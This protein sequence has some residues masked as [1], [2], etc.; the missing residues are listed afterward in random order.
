MSKNDY[1]SSLVNDFLNTLLKEP[2]SRSTTRTE[3][4]S[5]QTP[6]TRLEKKALKDLTP[7]EYDEWRYSNC[8][9]IECSSCPFYNVSCDVSSS[10]SWVHHKDLYSDKF[11]NQTVSISVDIPEPPKFTKEEAIWLSSAVPLLCETSIISSNEL[12]AYFVLNS[13]RALV[14]Y[15]KLK[16][17]IG[18]FNLPPRFKFECLKAKEVYSLQD[19]KD[20]GFDAS[21]LK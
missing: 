5:K 16:Q 4:T 15:D 17:I 18:Q 6:K 3:D 13:S 10:R 20:F 9:R 12:P 2:K 19:F 8:E 14:C 7:E 11:L 21:P 1:P